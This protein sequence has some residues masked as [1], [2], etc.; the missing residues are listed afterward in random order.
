MA[1]KIGINSHD[2]FISDEC[3]FDLFAVSKEKPIWV[4]LSDVRTSDGRLSF[5][6][7]HLNNMDYLGRR[8][9]Q[10][11]LMKHKVNGTVTFQST[12]DSNTGAA[13]G[14]HFYDGELTR[15]IGRLV[16][17]PESAK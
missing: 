1:W 7:N 8:S 6:E 4:D 15:L 17:T 11:V 9:I 14:Y 2:L 12:E 16:F 3:A 10:D 13:W 5:K